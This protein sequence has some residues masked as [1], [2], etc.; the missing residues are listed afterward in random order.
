MLVCPTS[1]HYREEGHSPS[2]NEASKHSHLQ[3][4]TTTFYTQTHTHTHSEEEEMIPACDGQ[5]FPKRNK[6]NVVRT[7]GK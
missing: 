3:Y 1:R 6:Q 7:I 2:E 5:K 4:M